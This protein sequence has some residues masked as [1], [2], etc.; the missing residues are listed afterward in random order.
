MM[1]DQQYIKHL[2]KQLH[3]AESDRDNWKIYFGCVLAFAIMLFG[4]LVFGMPHNSN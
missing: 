2:E 1:T 3:Q 4:W